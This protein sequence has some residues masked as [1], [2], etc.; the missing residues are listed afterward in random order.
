MGRVAPGR[1]ARS[2]TSPDYEVGEDEKI[3]GYVNERRPNNWGRWGEDDERGTTNLITPDRVREAASLIS[4]GRT[5]SMAIPLNAKGPVH[6]S[7]PGVQHWYG[8]SGS[9]M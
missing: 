1:Y 3:V 7:R 6:P 2:W 5:V 9:D 4:S 8:Y